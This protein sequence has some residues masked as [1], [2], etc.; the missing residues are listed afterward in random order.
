[1]FFRKEVRAGR[2]PRPIPMDFNFDIG[3]YHDALEAVGKLVDALCEKGA[4][5]ADLALAIINLQAEI[6]FYRQFHARLKCQDSITDAKT[7]DS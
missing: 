3:E 5:E 4:T 7:A 1:M 6:N 2:N